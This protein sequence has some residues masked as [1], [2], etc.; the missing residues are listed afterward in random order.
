[1]SKIFSSVVADLANDLIMCFP[2]DFDF[3]AMLSKVCEDAG[4]CI[5]FDKSVGGNCYK[6]QVISSK[7]VSG[8]GK[9]DMGQNTIRWTCRPT[10]SEPIM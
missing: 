4:V 7:F 3:K 2:P 8:G 10:H 1:M 6:L 9:E 5:K